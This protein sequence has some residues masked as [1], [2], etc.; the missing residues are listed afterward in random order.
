MHLPTAVDSS[1]DLYYAVYV[2]A[3]TAPALSRSIATKM[4]YD[5]NTI[6]RTTIINK[7][8]MH[9]ALDD[10]VVREMLDKQD[11]RVAVQE[12]RIPCDAQEH[13]MSLDK[14]AGLELFLAF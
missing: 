7:R 6:V 2:P 1:H 9:L 3:R 10:E 13:D 11:M 12:I 14:Q 8:G 5:P 4:G